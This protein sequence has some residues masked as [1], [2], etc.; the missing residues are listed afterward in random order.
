MSELSSDL[1][2]FKMSEVLFSAKVMRKCTSKE[3]VYVYEN[4]LNKNKSID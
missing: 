2:I 3:V 1:E 4:R